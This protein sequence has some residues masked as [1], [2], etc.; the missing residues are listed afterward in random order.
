MLFSIFEHAY[1]LHAVAP[2]P[3]TAR[4]WEEW[5]A[6]IQGYCLRENFRRAWR[7]GSSSYDPRFVAYMTARAIAL[8][9]DRRDTAEHAGVTE[10]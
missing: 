5:D 8:V 3:I 2:T 6:H 10:R 4:Q 1:L 7:L 9:R